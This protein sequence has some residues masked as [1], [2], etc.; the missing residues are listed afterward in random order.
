[1]A[2]APGIAF[3]FLLRRNA[4]AP[5]RGR[6][7]L[8]VWFVF[9]YTKNAEMFPFPQIQLYRSILFLNEFKIKWLRHL[10]SNQGPSG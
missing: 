10:D 4:Q 1:M 7:T 9:C 5:L 8:R 2:P 6:T 3:R